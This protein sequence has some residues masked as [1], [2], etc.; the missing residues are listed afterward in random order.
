MHEISNRRTVLV[1]WDAAD[2]DLLNPLL[3]CGQLPHLQALVEHG[4]MG[5]MR[6]RGPLI[7][8]LVYS[9]VA[10]GKYA[11][12]H[13]ILGPLEVRGDGSIGP[14]TSESRTAKAFWEILCE[15]GC[16]CH[17]VNF[18]AVGPAEEVRGVFVAPHFFAAARPGSRYESPL[19]L[20]SVRPES[21]G[22]ALRELIV[23]LEEIDAETMATFVPRFRELEAADPRLL[24]IGA[25]V[26]HALSVHAVATWLMAQTPW[27]VI[28]VNYPLVDL[29]G[30]RFLRYHGAEQGDVGGTEPNLFR[31]V[32]PS[33]MRLCDMLLGRLIELAG[34]DADLM[35]YS[36]CGLLRRE[37]PDEGELEYR[38]SPR[39][40][41]EGICV[42]RAA[43]LPADEL[44]QEVNCT[45]ICPTLLRL[46]GL[47]VGSDMD[48][49][50]VQDLFEKNRAA[51]HS[52]VSWESA[53]TRR[54]TGATAAQHG[55]VPGRTFGDRFEDNARRRIEE[56]NLWTL[57]RAQLAAGRSEEAVP[58]MLRLYHANPLDVERGPLVAE[59]LYLAGYAEAA[60]DVMIPLAEA[61][62]D[63]AVGQFMGGFLALMR[64]DYPRALDLFRKAL[65]AETPFPRLS[66]YLGYG[67]LLMD[68]REEAAAAF[69]RALELDP[70]FQLSY[71][72]LSEALLR[73]QRLEEAGE[74]ALSAVGCGFA[75]P[76]GHIALG[77]ALSRLGDLPRAREAYATALK[78]DPENSVARAHLE[79]LER[80][81][82]ERP[83]GLPGGTA[84]GLTPPLYP[85][86]ESRPGSPT[87][88]E[89]ALGDIRAWRNAYMDD[90]EAAESRLDEYLVKNAAAIPGTLNSAAPQ[91]SDGNKETLEKL[92]AERWTLRPVEPADVPT[93]RDLI[94]GSLAEPAG[95][96]IFVAH[97]LGSATITGGVMLRLLHRSG[98]VVR[99]RV[100]LGSAPAQAETERTRAAITA[101][102][103]R[104]GVARA[105]SGG[106][107][108]IRCVV[109]QGTQ[110]SLTLCLQ[111]LG[112]EVVDVRDV[113]T[114]SITELRDLCQRIE[115]HYRRRNKIPDDVRLT[116][117]QHI[118]FSM[119][120][121][122][123]KQWFVDGLGDLRRDYDPT[124]GP[125]ILKGNEIIA[126]AIACPINK[127]MIRIPYTCVQMEYR[128]GWVTPSL[129]GQG[130]RIGA[131]RGYSVI[132]FETTER[133]S[134]FKKIVQR[135]LNTQSQGQMITLALEL[136]H[137]WVA[138]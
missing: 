116:S 28:S 111:E 21:H 49:R 37:G 74:A 20:R 119:L 67:Y 52:P 101:F 34:P 83:E 16:R 88:I 53:G 136:R 98:P 96:E 105:V 59:S 85:R 46:R 76:A 64:R 126:C 77:R 45:D 138:G 22:E 94:S 32:M 70:G 40:G 66:Y 129:F 113:L 35:L 3:D 56:Q 114:A 97:R 65:A 55:K 47:P 100:S 10:T 127:D 135:H 125:V 6:T 87:T 42:L 61:F 12:K 43:G 107:R 23:S 57:A 33:A 39:Y 29:L 130:T 63:T 89:G 124:L 41:S 48:G 81:A 82:R 79:L 121:S 103:L 24:E 117:A 108:E 30:A 132:E 109:R 104:A 44:I 25:A 120:D 69:R 78:L 75:Q 86:L 122:F 110:E 31:H 80:M 2:W 26:A 95:T 71:L 133:F 38:E 62:A 60:R 54:G 14:T 73:L 106:A 90:L 4:V 91:I 115:D 123:L 1:G 118:P 19:P 134:E 9:S 17:I 68:Q 131:E 7:G 58:L 5:T 128:R 8:P 137:R 50:A 13:G 18:P 11:D 72:G 102:L 112:F 92:R 15:Q 51:V 36:P 84:L 93:F 99:L 27:D